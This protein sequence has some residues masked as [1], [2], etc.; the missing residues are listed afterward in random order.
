MLKDVAGCRGNKQLKHILILV[1]KNFF[2]TL[3]SIC[4]S[5]TAIL[6]AVL[7]RFELYTVVKRSHS[8]EIGSFLSIKSSAHALAYGVFNEILHT[9]LKT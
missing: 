9:P 3:S 1:K 4:I 8:Y 6:D 5:H 7:G 2:L